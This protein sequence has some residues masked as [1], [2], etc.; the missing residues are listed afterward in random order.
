MQHLKAVKDTDPL[1][2]AVDTVQPERVAFSLRLSQS[3]PLYDAFNAL[4][5]GPAWSS[6]SPAQRR[7][8]DIELKD[9]RLGGVSLDGD[10]KE[11][12]NEIQQELSQLGTQFSNNVLDATKAF[13]KV[14][15]RGCGGG[16]GGGRLGFNTYIF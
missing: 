15:D 9:F 6:L 14:R 5:T 12:F 16:G 13:K 11:R 10:K 2:E 3:R 8:V 4:K 1:R 7:L